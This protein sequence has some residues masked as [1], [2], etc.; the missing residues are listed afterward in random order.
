MTDMTILLLQVL[1]SRF[2]G[3]AARSQRLVARAPFTFYCIQYAENILEKTIFVSGSCIFVD[4][5]H[6]QGHIAYNCAA[7][8][9]C[10]I[11]VIRLSCGANQGINRNRSQPVLQ[12]I[13][14]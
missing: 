13:K 4:F 3:P 6:Y 2:K 7:N 5:I 10:L 11:A 1:V 9:S 12:Q 14:P 8:N